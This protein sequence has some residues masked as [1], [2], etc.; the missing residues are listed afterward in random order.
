MASLPKEL[1]PLADE[2]RE[3]IVG[4]RAEVTTSTY[5]AAYDRWAA[6]ATQHKL[7]PTPADGEALALYLAALM[8]EGKHCGTLSTAASA[9][10]WTHRAAG[11][12]SPTDHQFVIQVLEAALR[13]RT[14][15]PKRCRPITKEIMGKMA[16]H[17]HHGNQSLRDMQML[18]LVMIG[19]HGMLCW[20]DL[21]Q[22]MIDRLVICKEFLKINLQRCKNDQFRSGSA[23]FIAQSSGEACPV[24]ATKKFLRKGKHQPGRHLFGWIVKLKGGSWC[25]RH[26]MSYNNALAG[27]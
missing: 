25:I 17:L 5:T 24:A 7:R 14:S 16:Q 13:T 3:V 27:F 6:W 21:R 26:T 11:L 2:M 8:K 23:V 9:I 18:V 19:F 1:Q 15:P 12:A 20:D 10:A 4:S 22:I